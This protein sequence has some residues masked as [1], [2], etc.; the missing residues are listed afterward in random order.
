MSKSQC[1]ALLGLALLK[2]YHHKYT[3]I[4]CVQHR[5]ILRLSQVASYFTKFGPDCLY[6]IIITYSSAC[7][8]NLLPCT[9]QKLQLSS[10]KYVFAL[11]TSFLA[12]ESQICEQTFRVQQRELFSRHF[13]QFQFLFFRHQ[14]WLLLLLLKQS[15]FHNE[16]KHFSKENQSESD[17]ELFDGGGLY[18][19]QVFLR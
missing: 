8:Q 16:T 12:M 14:L 15:H 7:S 17:T 6:G 5:S 3:S 18:Q 9:D 4:I 10:S 13:F 19:N 11:S 2:L 1:K